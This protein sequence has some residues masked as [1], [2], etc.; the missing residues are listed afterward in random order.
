MPPMSMKSRVITALL[1]TCLCFHG[2]RADENDAP[3]VDMPIKLVH[4][5]SSSCTKHTT[6]GIDVLKFRATESE[7]RLAAKRYCVEKKIRCD[8]ITEMCLDALNKPAL[9]PSTGA[10]GF[11]ATTFPW[12]VTSN[13]SGTSVLHRL[14]HAPPL[15]RNISRAC[16]QLP[17]TMQRPQKDTV[18]INVVNE[19]AVSCKNSWLLHL[20]RIPSAHRHGELY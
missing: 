8:V 5:D 12:S 9:R 17:H 2:H 1:S 13:S 18:C 10:T 7:A 19:D 4:P 6:C 11:E 20:Q 3:M 15:V 14:H 16:G